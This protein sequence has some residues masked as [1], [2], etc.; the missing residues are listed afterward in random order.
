MIIHILINQEDTEI[1]L[2]MINMCNYWQFK[3]YRINV[4]IIFNKVQTED[5]LL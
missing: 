1:Q 3:R 5:N 2:F 4:M